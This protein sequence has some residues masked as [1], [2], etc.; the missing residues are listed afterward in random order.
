M[1]ASCS[2][3]YEDR[4]LATEHD[5]YHDN[6][7][8]GKRR[9]YNQCCVTGGIRD[10]LGQDDSRCMYGIYKQGCPCTVIL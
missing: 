1:H 3:M 4:M 9:Q 8:V 10:V 6:M 7:H 2:C 5:M